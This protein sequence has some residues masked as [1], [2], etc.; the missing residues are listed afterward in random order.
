MANLLNGLYCLLLLVSLI[1]SGSG[2]LG[3]RNSNQ[4]FMK[5]STPRWALFQESLRELSDFRKRVVSKRDPHNFSDLG[6]DKEPRPDRLDL[7][8]VKEMNYPYDVSLDTKGMLHL[9]WDFD[10]V[11][12]VMTFNLQVRAPEPCIV[13]FGFSDHGDVTDADIVLIDMRDAGQE[14]AL[15]VSS[16]QL[17][18]DSKTPVKLLY[19]LILSNQI[20]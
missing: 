16:C 11:K 19:S 1:C 15:Q 4:K 20:K 9:Y 14:Q 13:G 5:P 3:N 10:L 6:K 2:K 7:A 18:F 12:E 8:G 17:G